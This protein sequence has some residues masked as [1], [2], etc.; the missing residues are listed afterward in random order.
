VGPGRL[1]S[2]PRRSA[3]GIAFFYYDLTAATSDA[4][5]EPY[6]LVPVSQLLVMGLDFA[7]AEIDIGQPLPTLTFTRHSTKRL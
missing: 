2:F 4:K 1:E 5:S 7:Y 3:E 6:K